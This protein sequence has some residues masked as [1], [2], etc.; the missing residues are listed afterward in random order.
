MMIERIL[1]GTPGEV[2][3]ERYEVRR[4]LGRNAGRRTFLALDLETQELVVVK[5]LLFGVDFQWDDLKLFEREADTLKALSHSAIPRYLNYFEIDVSNYK[6][7]G[8]VQTYVEGTSLEESLKAGRSF[9]EQEVQQIAK[10]LLEILIYLHE[11]QPPVIHR[12][13]KPSNILLAKSGQVDQVYLVD[14]GSV[15]AYAAKENSTFTVVGTY[16]YMPPEQF[17]GRTVP[18]SDLYALGVTLI[19]LV[20]GTYPADLPQRDLRIQFEQAATLSP[21]FADWLRWLAEPSLSQ[22]SPSALKALQ[23][24]QQGKRR[25][26]PLVVRQSSDSRVSLTKNA[27]AL[28]VVIPSVGFNV[29]TVCL[30]LFVI[31]L[32]YCNAIVLNSLARSGFSRVA[33]PFSLDLAWASVLLPF[34]GIG[35]GF[36]VVVLFVLFGRTRLSLDQQQ[37][38]LT[39]ELFGWKHHYPRSTHRQNIYKLEYIQG[40]FVTSSGG[41]T[42]EVPPRLIIWAGTQKYQLGAIGGLSQVELDWLAHEISD[43]L[44]LPLSEGLHE[45]SESWHKRT[46]E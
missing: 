40:P 34:F 41:Q 31:I 21:A 19:T 8:L 5:L 37:V 42:V 32:N 46:Q 33:G 39:Y 28:E 24:L 22:R 17:G 25:D 4:Q 11:R 29:G 30:S 26:S 35:V 3:H 12:D 36:L 27:N 7:F 44:N 2:L 9:S 13:I 43:W 38:A 16:G 10:A 20:T 1:S 18:A 15:Q 45:S 14:F 6:G 23:V